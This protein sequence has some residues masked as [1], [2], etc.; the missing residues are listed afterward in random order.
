MRTLLTL[1]LLW[2]CGCVAAVA[3]VQLVT[4][5]EAQASQAAEEI[6]T[7]SVAMP[8][9]PK[10]SVLVPNTSAPV[11]SP[12]KI[13]VRFQAVPPAVI[14]PESFKVLYGAFR[15]D[16]TNKITSVYKVTPA[17]LDVLEAQLPK[18]SHKLHLQVTDS[19]G[20]M[21]SQTLAFT[22]E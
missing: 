12:T 16:I 8:D 22:V 11:A 21:G 1:G 3:Q 2:A 6:S 20:R 4:A 18:G 14:Q 10:I 15:L 9:D 19:A 13:Q 17:G 5:E 7:K